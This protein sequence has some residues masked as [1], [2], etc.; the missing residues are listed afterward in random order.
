MGNDKEEK[1]AELKEEIAT[2]KELADEADDPE[3]MA[4][5]LAEVKTLEAELEALGAQ[6]TPPGNQAVEGGAEGAAAEAGDG[7]EAGDVQEAAQQ[8][9][10]V[11]SSEQEETDTF[12][13]T[14]MS[15]LINLTQ[16][17]MASSSR[18]S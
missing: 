17:K 7:Q 15:T 5:Y 6:S 2:C 8:A 18:M 3:Q 11:R 13:S 12:R 10:A 16:I 1:I 4:E 14:L 9:A